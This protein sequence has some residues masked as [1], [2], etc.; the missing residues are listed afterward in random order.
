MST[1]HIKKKYS[2]HLRREEQ[3]VNIGDY[4][5]R[6]AGFWTKQVHNL[7]DHIRSEGFLSAP[8]P[9][10]FDNSGRE[11]VSFLKGEVSNYPLSNNAA[12]IKALTS[13]AS[14][15]RKYH[16]ASQNFLIKVVSDEKCWQLPSRHPKEVICHG[17]FAPY[18][19][20]LNG[21]QAVGIIDFDTCHPGSRLWDVAYALY[22]WVPLTNPNNKDGFGSIDEQI[23]RACLF[24][25]AY[26]LAEKDKNGM[27]DLIIERLQVLV[28]FMFSQA[29]EGNETFA[30]N[31]Q[32]NHHLLYLADIEYIKSNQSYIEYGLST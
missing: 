20:V 9:V 11:I 32:D 27:I 12:S 23:I 15:L 19:V 17:D 18:N 22:R 31:I 30:A 14:L 29:A 24:C 16:D 7:L 4:I 10:G 21:E 3:I 5:Y 28:S 25:Q 2:Q 8:K 6:P 1:I 26:G 13:A